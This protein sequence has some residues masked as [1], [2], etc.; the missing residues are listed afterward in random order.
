MLELV[1]L[2]L[3]IVALLV[4]PSLYSVRFLCVFFQMRPPA[5]NFVHD[6]LSVVGGVITLHLFAYLKENEP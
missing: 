4:L 6:L 5:R 3:Q 2:Q 1:L